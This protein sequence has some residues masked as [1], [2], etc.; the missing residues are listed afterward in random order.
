MLLSGASFGQGSGRIA[1]DSVDCDPLVH[2]TLLQCPRHE[3]LGCV[4]MVEV[5]VRCEQKIVKSVHAANVTT[6]N[7]GTL[8]TVL[9]NVTLV[10]NNNIESF[11]VGCYNQRH[12][13]YSVSNNTNS[14]TAHLSGYDGQAAL[15]LHNSV[16]IYSILEQGL[17]LLSYVPEENFRHSHKIIHSKSERCVYVHDRYMCMM[18]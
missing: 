12:G 9:I 5:D 18:H 1:L 16:C 14:F 8:H 6:H 3:V 17:T 2:C 11:Q 13:V 7:Y 10:N 4:D 15:S